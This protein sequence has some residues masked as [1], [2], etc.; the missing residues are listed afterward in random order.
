MIGVLLTPAS[1]WEWE[2]EVSGQLRAPGTGTA[3]VWMLM[4]KEVAR[5][6]KQKGFALLFAPGLPGQ[7]QSE[8]QRVL[9]PFFSSA[10][11]SLCP[12]ACGFLHC[13]SL[14]NGTSPHWLPVYLVARHWSGSVLLIIYCK[15]LNLAILRNVHWYNCET[16]VPDVKTK[17]LNS[18]QC[19]GTEVFL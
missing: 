10:P 17:L 2:G 13:S 6:R 5:G 12:L 11:D 4:G 7:N 15:I 16:K 3:F 18:A 9:L 14:D 19:V 8:M 1:C